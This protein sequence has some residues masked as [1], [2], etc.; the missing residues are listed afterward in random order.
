MNTLIKSLAVRST[1][2]TDEDGK[3]IKVK[4]AYVDSEVIDIVN[5]EKNE[6]LMLKEERKKGQIEWAVVKRFYSLNG[7]FWYVFGIFISMTIW[8]ALKLGSSVWLSLWTENNEES[9]NYYYLTVYSIM[10]IS[11]GIFAMTRAAICLKGS[12][13]ESTIIHRE[14]IS[15]LMF[16]PLNEFFERVPIG[17]ILN[18]L[19]KDI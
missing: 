4:A 7:G 11:Y 15:S 1:V 19:S 18:I 3:E 8:E 13:N 5:Q 17:R 6:I 2:E 10:S 16:A 14:I 12:L 9:T